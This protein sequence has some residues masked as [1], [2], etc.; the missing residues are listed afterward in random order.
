MK[1][2]GSLA[3]ALVFAGALH[4][5]P[6]WSAEVSPEMRAEVMKLLDITGARK[7]GEQM[8]G[9]MVAQFTRVLQ[10]S[11]PKL[12]Q[13]APEV[14]REEVQ[15]TI[16]A[17]RDEFD[18]RMVE[19]Y[20]RYFTLEDIQGLNR[21]YASDLGKKVTGSLPE[22]LRDSL[23]SGGA[24]GRSL[25]PEIARRIE[26]RFRKEGFELQKPLVQESAG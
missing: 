21:F 16:A 14:V 11:N 22:V 4:A 13:D 6:A 20:A 8:A 18:E 19:I 24:W 2:L 23:A 15:A 5:T 9:M 12:P 17:H 7:L 3:A 25:G 26:A 1:I 10:A